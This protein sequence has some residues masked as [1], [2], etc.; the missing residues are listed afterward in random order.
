MAGVCDQHDFLCGDT[1]AAGGDASVR[2]A[3]AARSAGVVCGVWVS[4]WGERDLHRV[5]QAGGASWRCRCMKRRI[6]KL[7]LFLLLGAM[8]NVAVAWGAF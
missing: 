7:G 6:V 5:R 3:V 2:A 4:G 8:V 1:V